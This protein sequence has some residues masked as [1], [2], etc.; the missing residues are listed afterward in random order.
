M[1]LAVVVFLLSRRSGTEGPLSETA[2]AESRANGRSQAS[3]KEVMQSIVDPSADVLWGAVGTVVDRENGVQELSPKT[4][5]EWL[6][7]R[8]AAIRILEGGNLLTLKG[9]NA[10]PPGTRSETPGVELEPAEIAALIDKDRSTFDAFAKALQAIGA[11]AVKAADEKNIDALMDIG[12][13]MDNVCESCH[14]AF[15]YPYVSGYRSPGRSPA[16]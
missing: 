15:W 16:P 1:A 6:N 7:V 8:N 2:A 9:R 12:T 13:R 14:G 4:P 11:E 10:A 5:E 3:I